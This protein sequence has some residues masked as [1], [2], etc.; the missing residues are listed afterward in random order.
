MS[1]LTIRPLRPA[2]ADRVGAL[3][4]AAYDASGGEITGP[5]R[6][7]LADPRL[8]LPEVTAVLVAVDEASGEV[9]GTVTYVR[10]GDGGFEHPLHEGDAGFRALAVDPAAQGR[11][12][13]D[14]L[15]DACLSRAREDGAHRVVITSMA[16]MARAHDLY[17]RR[18]FTRRPDLDVRFPSGRGYVFTLDLTDE[19]VAR[20]GAPGPAPDEVPWFEDAWGR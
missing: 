18:G 10:P 3:T 14:R 16:W 7:W 5:Y 2:E 8:R 11:G 9:V 12:V 17:R 4:L 20:F 15:V 1:D 6:D 19:A 13:G